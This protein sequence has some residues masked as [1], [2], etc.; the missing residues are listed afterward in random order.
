MSRSFSNSFH[1]LTEV[2]KTV[3]SVIL[4]T[5]GSD[6]KRR[7]SFKRFNRGIKILPIDNGFSD[8]PSGLRINSK[9]ADLKHNTP[10]R[11]GMMEGDCIR[12]D[13]AIFRQIAGYTFNP[14]GSIPVR[15]PLKPSQDYLNT[16]TWF[17]ESVLVSFHPQF[18]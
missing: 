1:R 18:V 16:L 5:L 17:L 4:T 6:L 9:L 7:L 8:S 14:L 11:N 15:E 13:F 12:G 10:I 3:Q 2:A